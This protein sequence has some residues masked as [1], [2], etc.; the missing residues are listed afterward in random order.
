MAT[1]E[2]FSAQADEND[3]KSNDSGIGVTDMKSHAS[4]AV[5]LK[6]ELTSL[7]MTVSWNEQS[8]IM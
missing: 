6:Y 5:V 4:N 7:I 8:R 3:E 2:N 1:G